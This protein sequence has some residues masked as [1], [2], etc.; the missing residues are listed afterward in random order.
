MCISGEGDHLQVLL[1]HDCK[2]VHPLCFML[3]H[4]WTCL[5][6]KSVPVSPLV[7]HSK[8]KMVCT[9]SPY[10]FEHIT[11]MR[12]CVMVVYRLE[13]RCW[14]NITTS[15]TLLKWKLNRGNVTISEGPLTFILPPQISI[16]GLKLIILLPRMRSA[17]SKAISLSLLF[18]EKSLDLS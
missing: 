18:T 9:T 17:R 10:G 12:V 2:C 14:E 3:N 4:V 16:W 5:G 6:S 13:P 1:W 7:S 11:C 15:G 8:F